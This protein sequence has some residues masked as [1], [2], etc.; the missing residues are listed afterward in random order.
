MEYFKFFPKTLYIFGD[1]ST[2]SGSGNV[3]TEVFTDISAYSEVVDQ[4]RKNTA[5]HTKYYIQENERPDQTSLKLYGTTSYHWTFSYMNDHLR[6][7]GWPVNNKQLDRIVKRDFPHTVFTTTQ[8]LTRYML[9]G[10]IVIGSTSGARGK[11]IRRKLD[12]GQI[13]IEQLGTTKFSSTEVITGTNL[14]A[15]STQ[16]VLGNSVLEYNAVHHYE[17]SDGEYVDIDPRVGPGA[18]LTAVTN[19]D[20]YIKR[21]DELKSITVIKSQNVN[22]VASLFRQAMQK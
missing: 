10:Q 9:P 17:N 19:Y 3:V 18:L 2:T 22:E 6:S 8:D 12:L 7:S 21:N 13:I 4:V 14:S 11:V 20:R 16:S 5:F 1:E 15:V